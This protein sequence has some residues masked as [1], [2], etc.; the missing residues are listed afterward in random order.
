MRKW[1]SGQRAA[2]LFA[3]AVGAA[4]LVIV[5][6]PLGAALLL[7]VIA[8]FWSAP[9]PALMEP[10]TFGERVASWVRPK[11]KVILGLHKDCWRLGPPPV[12]E[13]LQKTE[14]EGLRPPGALLSPVTYDSLASITAAAGV[15]M[16]DMA[17]R[18]WAGGLG[19]PEWW[20][21]WEALDQSQIS[22]IAPLGSFLITWML[23]SG[24]IASTREMVIAERECLA[25]PS[26]VENSL[27]D[28]L[29]KFA[30]L[31]LEPPKED[32]RTPRHPLFGTVVY[33][34]AVVGFAAVEV[35]APT[36]T[37]VAGWWAVGTVAA[38]GL[39]LLGRWVLAWDAELQRSDWEYRQEQ[40]S[41]WI[42]R[43]RSMPGMKNL[44]ELALP[45]YIRE[46][47]L[48]E[49]SPS[50]FKSVIM[51]WQGGHDVSEYEKLA[52]KLSAVLGTTRILVEPVQLQHGHASY[53]VFTV[54]Y[55]L[56][57][58]GVSPHLETSYDFLTEQ[59]VCRQA[60]IDVFASLKLGHP[61]HISSKTLTTETSKSVIKETILSLTEGVTVDRVQEKIDKIAEKLGCEWAR[62]HVPAGTTYL[63]LYYGGHPKRADFQFGG[64][65]AAVNEADWSA[66]M[67]QA[68]LYGSNRRTPKMVGITK[69]PLGLEELHFTLPPGLEYGAVADYK[70]IRKMSASSSWAY[71]KPRDAANDPT[72]FSLIL[73]DKDPLDDIFYFRKYKEDILKQPV[74]GQPDPRW[75]VGVGDQGQL[76]RYEWDHEEPH[77][78]IAGSSGSGKSAI[79]NSCLT[80]IL[81]NNSP[82][83]L[84]MW[85]ADPK[86]ELQTYQHVA[87]VRRFIDNF[88]VG[89]DSSQYQAISALFGEAVAEMD[90]RY[91]SFIQHPLSPKKLSEARHIAATEPNSSHL[92]YP[93]LLIVVEEC[94]SYYGTPQLKEDRQAWGEMNAHLSELA[95]K[96]RAAGIHIISITQYPTNAYI[97]QIIKQ[98]SR[99]LGLS[100]AD[101]VASRVI[102]DT[103]GLEVIKSKGRGLVSGDRGFDEFRGFLMDRPDTNR[104]DIPDDAAEILH[105]LPADLTW[106]KLPPGVEPH[107][108]AIGRMIYLP[109]G[110]RVQSVPPNPDGG[111]LVVQPPPPQPA[112]QQGPPPNGMP[113][114]G[115]PPPMPQPRPQP[116]HPQQ[117]QPRP[118]PPQHQPLPPQQPHPQSQQH[119]PRPQQ[120]PHPQSQQP[121]PRPQQPV[122]AAHAGPRPGEPHQQMPRIPPN[123]SPQHQEEQR[124]RTVS[125]LLFGD[126]PAP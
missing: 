29:K 108:T 122:A 59:F 97:P 44:D 26:L 90:R 2:V 73:G 79:V 57:D 81:H 52:S 15:T 17:L 60:V 12:S 8:L 35:L 83:D 48:P 118:Q 121:Q 9:D 105:V 107:P 56:S 58:L 43:W 19:L 77:L 53:S 68:H 111:E 74:R 23:C 86:N 13:E 110:R 21:Q 100:T 72:R 39:L 102:I 10:G 63:T 70:A 66:Y 25:P 28:V 65:K 104:P 5:H 109:D 20:P 125:D 49:D 113:P 14:P 1:G 3:A 32:K 11:R 7:V 47:D 6:V 31:K 34:L 54:S 69:T 94:S 99:R 27:F 106:P 18:T 55:E 96:S 103:N 89:P 64:D 126:E 75:V 88:V 101:L 87:H 36:V 85:L 120:Q 42:R 119:Q 50:T 62:T 33:L 92:A 71:I 123:P 95:R 67:G 37:P 61:L 16:A 22:P 30:A 45:S 40:I 24:L 41:E 114:N 80:Q 117:Q 82:E 115:Q 116:Q 4:T 84:H 91:S 76:I 38:A 51:Q 93:I 46:Q 112:P 78:L 124:R 98:Q